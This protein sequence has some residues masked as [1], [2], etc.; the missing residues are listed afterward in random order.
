MDC[1]PPSP[2]G[3]ARA[4]AAAGLDEA[5]LEKLVRAFYGLARQD[6]EIGPIFQRVADWEH[7]I[8]QITAFW[9]SVVFGSG[10]YRGRPMQAHAPLGL[11]PAHFARWLTLFERTARDLCPPAGAALLIDRARRIAASLEAGLTPL[12]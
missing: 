3:P 12:G 2:E 1:S 7:H 9:S 10:R 6:A 5:M 4:A 8:A 11:T